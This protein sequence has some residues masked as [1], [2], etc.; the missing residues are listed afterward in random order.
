MTTA[1]PLG[2]QSGAAASAAP[3]VPSGAVVLETGPQASSTGS[4]AAAPPAAARPASMPESPTGVLGVAKA[5]E[6]LK[7]GAEPKLTV[8]SPGAEPREK[9]SYD[10]AVGKKQSLALG[11]GM[12]LQMNAPGRPMPKTQIPKITMLFDL[13]TTGKKPSGDFDVRGVISGVELGQPDASQKAAMDQMKAQLDGIKGL[14]MTYVVSPSGRVRDVK[15]TVPGDAKSAASQALGQMTQS[16]ESMVAPL[17]VDPVGIGA[18]WEVITRVTATGADMLQWSTYELKKRE[19][20][21]FEL[22]VRVMQLA[23]QPNIQAPGMPPGMTARLVRMSSE[24]QGTSALS[25]IEVA[26]RGGGMTLNTSMEIEMSQSSAMPTGISAQRMGFDT[27]VQME[28]TRPA[29][30]PAPAP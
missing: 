10:L 22:G 14:T 1:S 17:P 4:V 26:P 23:A 9:L 25:L 2:S 29:A 11:L 27:R 15:V 13:E 18:K 5:D 6:I 8:L 3:P 16:F 28:F 21:D 30:A 12:D 20:S 24:G 19:G 7:Q